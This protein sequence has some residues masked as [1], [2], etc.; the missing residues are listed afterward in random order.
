MVIWTLGME[1]SRRIRL[2]KHKIYSLSQMSSVKHPRRE[3][4]TQIN[5][6]TIKFK[7]EES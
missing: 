1:S 5:H 2:V 6:S 4:R 3:G 7:E